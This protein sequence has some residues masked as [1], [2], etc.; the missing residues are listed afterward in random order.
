ML[1]NTFVAKCQIVLTLK[2]FLSQQCF[3]SFKTK[4]F[5][6][7]CLKNVSIIMNQPNN[8]FF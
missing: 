4:I 2:N 5:N 3:N 6:K 1:T 8:Y 7:K